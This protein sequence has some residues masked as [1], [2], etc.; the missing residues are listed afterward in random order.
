MV[1]LWRKGA[2]ANKFIQKKSL[3]IVGYIEAVLCHVNVEWEQFS[4]KY[5]DAIWTFHSSDS[6]KRLDST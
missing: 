1:K 5:S 2:L 4:L 6:K 3:Q